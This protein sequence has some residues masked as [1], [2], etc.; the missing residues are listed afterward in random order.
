[1]RRA[2]EELDALND[3]EFLDEAGDDAALAARLPTAE[4]PLSPEALRRTRQRLESRVLVEGGQAPQS[5]PRITPRDDDGR[6]VPFSP[7]QA[8]VL[9]PGW[10]PVHV[11]QSHRLELLAEGHERIGNGLSG[12]GAVTMQGSGQ[13]PIRR[14]TV[15]VKADLEHE[16]LGER[17]P[18]EGARIGRS[19]GAYC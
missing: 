18:A 12:C 2:S 5:F 17:E 6:V 4:A 13:L 7:L 15:G 9:S 14:A 1:V 11:D 3:D 19:S 8:R 16:A 10:L